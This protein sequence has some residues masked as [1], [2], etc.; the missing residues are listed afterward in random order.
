M[1]PDIS[2]LLDAMDADGGHDVSDGVLDDA[3]L[4]RMDVT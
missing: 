2:V 3:G 1:S 4:I